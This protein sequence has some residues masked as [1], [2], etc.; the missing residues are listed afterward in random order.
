MVSHVYSKSFVLAS[1]AMRGVSRV[2]VGEKLVPLLRRAARRGTGKGKG[3]DVYLV[4]NA[5]TMDSITGWIFGVGNSTAMLGEVER[6]GGGEW[7][8]WLYRYWG[9]FQY[10]FWGQEV[11]GFT[12][13]MARIGIQLVPESVR[14]ADGEIGEWVIGMCEGARRAMREVESGVEVKPE[15]VPTVY[16]RLRTALVKERESQGVGKAGE[17]DVDGEKLVEEASL[18]REI[19]SELWDHTGK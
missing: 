10:R 9:R 19:A 7:R 14:N 2:V 11:P 5:A 13:W 18:Q 1:E 15:E 3:V 12:R 4:F 16:S 6:E 8:E 17:K